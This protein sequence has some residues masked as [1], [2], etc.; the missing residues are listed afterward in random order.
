M[1][2]I[3]IIC[4]KDAESMDY[5][6]GDVFKVDSVWYG[7]VNVTSKTGVPVSLEKEEYEECAEEA[8]HPIDAYSYG[9]GA[10]D[11]FYEM[12]AAGVK[13][14]AMSHPCDTKEER[15]LWI[16]DVK[17]LCQRYG[18]RFGA[19]DEPFLT[20]LFP[21]EQ[22]RGKYLF[23]FYRTQETMDRYL[24]LKDEK[25]R[26]EENGALTRREDE[27]I[28]V[29]FGRL[30]SYPQEGIDRLIRAAAASEEDR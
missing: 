2:K 22:S 13:E 28:A 21:K 5:E 14:L 4:K 26:L 18:I 1:K 7:G 20:A 8:V 24:A 23:L 6:V 29:E 27:R 10:M 9:L 11:C 3:R 12:V 17:K 25:R 30:L 16:P 15:D 19:E